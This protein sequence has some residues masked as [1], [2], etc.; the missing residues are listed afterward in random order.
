MFNLENY[1]LLKKLSLSKDTAQGAE[2]Y[3]SI[4]DY[5]YYSAENVL[6]IGG[7]KNP[8]YKSDQKYVVN[9]ISS[10]ELEF[11]K[12]DKSSSTIWNF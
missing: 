11:I 3:R 2:Y 4:I 1:P 5:F 6:E 10:Y 12:K 7:G 8:T 9:D